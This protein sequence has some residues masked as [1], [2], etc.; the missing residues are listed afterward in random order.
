MQLLSSFGRPCPETW[1]AVC[2]LDA[3]AFGPQAWSV[4]R[5]DL[6]RGLRDRGFALTVARAGVAVVGFAS[7]VCVTSSCADE[8][9]AAGYEERPL[10][11]ADV[12][13]PQPHPFWYGTAL[14]VLP[15]WTGQGLGS[16]LLARTLALLAGAGRDLEHVSVVA[17]MG[18]AAGRAVFARFG[19]EPVG[20]AS[21]R[22]M[23]PPARVAERTATFG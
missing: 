20:P 6:E 8:V 17:Q 23:A 19:A 13:S 10:S 7:A 3:A 11:L 9:C 2:A 18:S 5:P 21:M 1:A 4:S 15:G 12:L 16:R 14:F 22:L